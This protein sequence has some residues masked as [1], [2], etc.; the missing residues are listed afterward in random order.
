MKIIFKL[1]RGGGTDRLRLI[2]L[3]KNCG[4]GGP[5]RNIGIGLSR[6]EYIMFTDSD[7]AI[8]PTAISELLN[9]AQK[10]S[11]DVVRCEGIYFVGKDQPFTTR[12]DL[13]QNSLRKNLPINKPIL[14]SEDL[15][16]RAKLFGRNEF[17]AASWRCFLRREIIIK[18]EI[19][20]SKFPLGE[21]EPFVFQLL[22]KSKKFLLV[23]N[24]V[25][26]I[27]E[28]PNSMTHHVTNIENTICKYS[29]SIA[30]GIR[31]LDQIM[32]GF[33]IFD[34]HCEYRYAIF[35]RFF[36]NK[37][38]YISNVYTRVPIYMVSEIVSR[39]LKKLDICPALAAFLLNRMNIFN[40]QLN[41]YGAII[42]QQNQLIQQLQAQIQK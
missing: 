9:L 10:F 29:Y 22:L 33:K 17:T 24:A 42:Q 15:S 23:P 11:V 13:I 4:S 14:L 27:R 28:N 35:E 6:G 36:R 16:E 26:I 39:E 21:D 8:T 20:F 19:H 37:L 3:E 12:V 5:T 18:N 30:E 38:E 2:R 1:T 34:E 7:D 40:L 25:N 32:N 41:Q 31:E